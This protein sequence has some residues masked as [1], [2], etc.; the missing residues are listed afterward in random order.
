MINQILSKLGLGDSS[1]KSEAETRRRH[2]RRSGVRTDVI[3][4]NH[5][6][7]VR[8]WSQSGVF[9]D[10]VPDV[11]LAVGDKVQVTMRFRLPHETVDIQQMAR[12]VRAANRGIAA[13][14][15]P[16]TAEI[17]RKFDRVIDGF[18]TQSFLESQVA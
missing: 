8:D 11:P 14:F 12:V 18:N 1:L 5:T 6:F 9:F 4:G 17:R 15:S 2:M 16:L 3:V 13:E 7:G 10:I